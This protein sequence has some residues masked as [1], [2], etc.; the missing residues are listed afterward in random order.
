MNVNE[1]GIKEETGINQLNDQNSSGLVTVTTGTGDL[2]NKEDI[3][4]ASIQSSEEK[5]DESNRNTNERESNEP[6]TFK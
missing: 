6:T 1:I 5:S 3:K 4:K 2:F